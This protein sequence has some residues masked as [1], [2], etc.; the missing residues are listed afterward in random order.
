MDKLGGESLTKHPVKADAQV[1]V[2]QPSPVDNP[3]DTAI[4]V[5]Q[6][7]PLFERVRFAQQ[8]HDW[9][10]LLRDPTLHNDLQSH[11]TLC[12]MWVASFRHVKQHICKVHEPE[13][14]GLHDR[15]LAL[16]LSFKHPPWLNLGGGRNCKL[17]FPGLDPPPQI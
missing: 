14:P 15:A 7:A 5:S 13:T 1:V 2:A 17:Q 6:N 10:S 11:C 12:H 3:P 4:G 9:E 16:C 8:C